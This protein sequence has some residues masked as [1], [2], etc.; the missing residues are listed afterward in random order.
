MKIIVIATLLILLACSTL[1]S[2]AST[3]TNNQPLP[4]TPSNQAQTITTDQPIDGHLYEFTYTLNFVRELGFGKVADLLEQERYQDALNA[5]EKKTVSGF[6]WSTDATNGYQYGFF[7]EALKGICLEKLGEVVK[8]YRSYQNARYYCDEEKVSI[9]GKPFTAPKLEVY[10]GIGRICN[11]AERW[12]DS[13]NYL[14]AARM[15]AA[16]YPSIAVAADR[17]L[18]KRAVEIG[19]YN[20]SMNMYQDLGTFIALNPA[21][22]ADYSKV[23]F[24]VKKDR[25]S[26]SQLLHGI[27]VYGIDEKMGTKNPIVMLFINALTRATNDEIVWFYDLLG[28]KLRSVPLKKQNTEFIVE[29]MK[30]RLILSRLLPF[31]H[32]NN[33]MEY[34]ASRVASAKNSVSYST[35]QRFV[36]AERKDVNELLSKEILK[37][38]KK[39]DEKIPYSVDAKI[40][41]LLMEVEMNYPTKLYAY[42][43]ISILLTNKQVRLRAY[44][45]ATVDEVINMSTNLALMIS[46]RASTNFSLIDEHLKIM[47][48]CLSSGSMYLARKLAWGLAFISFSR[49]KPLSEEWI[50]LLDKSS[51]KQADPWLLSA[52][53]W[54]T[55]KAFHVG[56][57]D[58]AMKWA[59]KYENRAGY[60]APRMY[61][62]TVG[63]MIINGDRSSAIKIALDALG[64]F[65]P[66]RVADWYEGQDM[67]WFREM[68]RDLSG[69]ADFEELQDLARKQLLA[70]IQQYIK[71]EPNETSKYRLRRAVEYER[72]TQDNEEKLRN[73]LKDSN[74]DMRRGFITN[75]YFAQSRQIDHYLAKSEI[76][77]S[78]GKTNEAEKC[79]VEAEKE[80]VYIN[81]IIEIPKMPINLTGRKNMPLTTD[82]VL[83]RS[84][85]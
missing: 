27:A 22:I 30:L 7:A 63:L 58:K 24:S 77:L 42:N 61:Y 79:I 47:E 41:D 23:M 1:V 4:A 62:K 19:D 43:D 29:I 14:D 83:R 64:S 74:V 68:C 82:Y 34:L 78:L 52:L 8:A 13:L 80:M 85:K 66:F 84:I 44:D 21:E 18:I 70:E 48:D 5:I 40:E 20:E 60:M 11:A 2:L 67:Y 57:I 28:Y 9:H 32:E 25:E 73:I 56:E 31:I 15:E 72:T 26:F 35:S 46:C 38:N 49:E 12:T 3:N 36:S 75:N 81:D 51:L 10:V 69:S 55:D 39:A 17:A 65:Y 33:D 76:W 71:R 54:N 37:E 16:E 45:N 6:A 53:D 59:K 50:A